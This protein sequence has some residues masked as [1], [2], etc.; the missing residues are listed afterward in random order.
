MLSGGGIT[1]AFVCLEESTVA[2]QRRNNARL[3]LRSGSEFGCLAVAEYG[4]INRVIPTEEGSLS[5]ML[6]EQDPDRGGILTGEAG[7][8]RSLFHRDDTVAEQC[9]RLLSSGGITP[10]FDS[11]QAPSSF[12]ERSRREQVRSQSIISGLDGCLAV[13][14]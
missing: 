10:A 13:A 2:D 1:P 9:R 5:V 11:A 8:T 6:D 3:R 7:R 4:N 14:E 12:P